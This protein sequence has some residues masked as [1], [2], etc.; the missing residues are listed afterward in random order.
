MFHWWGILLSEKS[1]DLPK[2]T[3]WI[4]ST[5]CQEDGK[6]SSLIPIL[7]GGYWTNPVE[8]GLGSPVK[9]GLE[10]TNDLR[11]LPS[12]SLRVGDTDQETHHNTAPTGQQCSV[13]IN[14]TENTEEGTRSHFSRYSAQ[15]SKGPPF[16]GMDYYGITLLASITYIFEDTYS[17]KRGGG[18]KISNHDILGKSQP[19]KTLMV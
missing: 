4:Q 13:R 8:I 18:K 10:K 12:L 6:G 7:K 15:I 1:G 16:V 2:F 19:K 11:P 5:L 17:T 9:A 14:C 3:A